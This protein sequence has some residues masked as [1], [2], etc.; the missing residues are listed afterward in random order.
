MKTILEILEG[1]QFLNAVNSV[2]R[3][4][5]E[6]LK[7][8]KS[9]YDLGIELI[10]RLKSF[11]TNSEQDKELIKQMEDATA[12]LK[13]EIDQ[14]EQELKQLKAAAKKLDSNG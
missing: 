8:I 3:A 12:K 4:I 13:G 14:L 7:H 1:R 11:E 5:T 10:E 2:E 6:D 9:D